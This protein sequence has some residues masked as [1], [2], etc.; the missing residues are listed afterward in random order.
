MLDFA[1]EKRVLSLI[2]SEALPNEDFISKRHE[3]LRYVRRQYIAENMLIQDM[4]A[5]SGTIRIVREPNLNYG[6]IYVLEQEGFR[7]GYL[8]NTDIVRWYSENID[9]AGSEFSVREILNA[10]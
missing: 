6:Y 7:S 2:N 3:F 4:K 9:K 8:Y 1:E 10:K 5:V